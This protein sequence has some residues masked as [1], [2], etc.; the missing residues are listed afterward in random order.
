MSHIQT[1]SQ[2]WA[3]CIEWPCT[4]IVYEGSFFCANLSLETFSKGVL[5]KHCYAKLCTD[6][7]ITSHQ[8]EIF[9]VRVVQSWAWVVTWDLFKNH[10]FVMKYLQ[11]LSPQHSA[12]FSSILANSVV[13]LSNPPPLSS[14]WIVL[15][16]GFGFRAAPHLPS[17]PRAV[18]VTW[19]LFSQDSCHMEELVASSWLIVTHRSKKKR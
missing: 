7:Y 17:Y 18:D 13:M 14:H 16:P 11:S 6:N 8:K 2:I 10:L 5:L 1:V 12:F 4:K 19:N 3:C 15:L 9:W